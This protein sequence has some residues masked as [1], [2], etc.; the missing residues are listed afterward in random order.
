MTHAGSTRAHR[1]TVLA[2]SS[3]GTL[4]LLDAGS[5]A[6]RWHRVNG[7]PLAGIEHGGE[8]IYLTRIS[9]AP[10]RRDTQQPLGWAE[11]A[12]FHSPEERTR[13][14]ELVMGAELVA[15]RAD[16]GSVAWR[17]AGWIPRNWQRPR[18]RGGHQLDGD[19]AITDVTDFAESTPVI[20]ALDARTGAPRWRYTGTE[21]GETPES[22][23]GQVSGGRGDNPVQRANA[24]L[25]LLGA[26][27]GRVY[28]LPPE[29]KRLDVLDAAS[30]QL[31]WSCEQA[32][33]DWCL[34]TG[35]VLL[36]E[37]SRR[38]GSLVVR[39]ASDG[40][41][42]S[43][44]SLPPSTIL[45]GLTDV[46]IA[47]LSGGPNLHHWLEALDTRTTE[48]VWRAERRSPL[49][50]TSKRDFSIFADHFLVTRDRLYAAR[51][52]HSSGLAEA[53]ALDA[54]SGQQQWYWHSPSHLLALLGLWGWRTPQVLAYALSELRWSLRRTSEQTAGKSIW[55][56]LQSLWDTFKNEML[57]GQWRRPTALLSIVFSAALYPGDS[58]AG[59]QLFIGTSMGLSALR[60]SDRRLLWHELLM[61]QITRVIPEP[62]GTT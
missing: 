35:G 41:V 15:L 33:S 51:Y 55:F 21:A 45:R 34:S 16:D 56:R 36:A 3:H 47:Y 1:P 52:N 44:L 9:R 24:T 46:G 8:L 39:Q 61:M 5:G 40:T 12:P 54:Q 43:T 30:G 50:F 31:L 29:Q 13:L 23:H 53:L 59:D 14:N 57:H 62:P 22:Q 42:I 60:G 19:V 26:S 6:V 32:D 28:V 11:R 7:R 58:P 18:A 10:I 2:V 4:W 25:N 20:S 48:T 27:A 49:R 38:N 17:H 37:R